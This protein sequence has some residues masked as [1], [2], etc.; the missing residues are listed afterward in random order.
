MRLTF[1]KNKFVL[2][3]EKILPVR[4]KRPQA[5]DQVGVGKFETTDLVAARQFER[6]ASPTVAKIFDRAF[7]KFYAP[8]DLILPD[9]L[10]FH[11]RDGVVW[12]LTRSRSYLAHPPGAGKTCEAVVASF[13]AVGEGQVVFIVPP[14]LT[15]NWKREIDFWQ[16][17]LNPFWGSFL[18]A[19][20]TYGY[21]IA[22]VPETT[23]Q[24][25]MNW[26][27]HYLIV[28]DSML[29][30]PWVLE[31][32]LALKKKFIA[33]DEASR[34]KE[35]TAERTKALFG[36]RLKNGEQTLGLI[37]GVPY[38]V[39]L[40]GSPMPN[41]PME[42]WAPTYALCP[43]A[44]DFMDQHSF[45]MS[46]CGARIND[47]GKWEYKFSSNEAVLKERLQKAFMHVVPESALSHPERRRSILVMNGDARSV[48]HQI[49]EASFLKV[50]S[51]ND[52]IGDTLADESKSQGQLAH[53]RAE[54]GM[55][56]VPWVANY[57]ADRLKN[58]NESILLFAWH[59]E[60]CFALAKKLEKFKPGLVMGGTLEAS[61][62]LHF[63]QFQRGKKKLLIM[64]I[65]AG[66]RGH[67]LQKADR[68]I[69]A[70]YSWCGET[71]L[72]AEK[73]AARK[74]RDS[75]MPV[76]CDYIVSPGSLDELILRAVMRKEKTVKQVIG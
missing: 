46:Y 33:V 25:E 10:D 57:V 15:A 1:E 6:Y 62:E 13:Y 55:R 56:K 26:G 65:A 47:F 42:L 34:F 69:F 45:G 73:R 29:T 22:I 9:F 39:M 17:C 36:G 49:Y 67:N 11:Q 3:P 40:D 75:E 44:I 72:Q 4:F 14:A 20:R 60:V 53:F 12:A 71:N 7:L 8:H 76:R 64:N 30:K 61:R 50:F 63:E 23:R 41:R 38:V 52:D 51:S 28:P 27:A 70:E 21:P 5:W 19:P 16:R 48:E 24:T 58:Q 35:A 68:V 18:L 74:G 43:E 59:R 37:A 66:G 2:R 32:L 54:L 31:K